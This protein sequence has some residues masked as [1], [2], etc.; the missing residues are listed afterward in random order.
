MVANRSRARDI[1]RRLVVQGDQVLDRREDVLDGQHRVGE[2]SVD[3]ELAVDL[4]AT[5]LRQVVAL[6]VEVEV[7]EERTR[8][9]GRNL[10]ARTELA[11]DVLERLFLG[12][13]GVLLEGERDRREALELLEDLL[14]RE[15]ERLQEDRDGLLALA[16]DANA[17]LVALVDLELEPCS[18][19]RDD[20]RRVDV[21]VGQLLRGCGR[22]RHRANAPA[23]TRRHARCR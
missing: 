11:V 16:V 15:A 13:D 1:R 20:A 18:A 4:V 9:L 8:G 5:H 7:V 17:D 23:A 10:L 2:R 22:S 14:A 19:A 21:L 3:T 12:E 6:A